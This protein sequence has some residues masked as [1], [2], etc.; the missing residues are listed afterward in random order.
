MF[1]WVPRKVAHDSRKNGSGD[2]YEIS[3]LDQMFS[4]LRL[5]LYNV[6]IF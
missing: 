1:P 5:L 2:Y 6:Q 4:N 3:F